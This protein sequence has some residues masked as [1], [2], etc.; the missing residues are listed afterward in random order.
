METID[1]IALI[2]L[3]GIT[4]IAMFIV[5]NKMWKK[6]EI[7]EQKTKDQH[8]EILYT[9]SIDGEAINKAFKSIEPRLKRI[10][11]SIFTPLYDKGNKVYFTNN[12]GKK[13][14]GVITK[15]FAFDSSLAT[16]DV[17]VGKHTYRISQEEITAWE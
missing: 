14:S 17:K 8:K 3:F 9:V 15:V 12:T 7:V 13:T 5:A 10:E 4:W 6:I 16:Y 11:S 2:I 1:Q